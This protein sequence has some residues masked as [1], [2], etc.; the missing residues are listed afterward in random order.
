MV[1]TSAEEARQ[2]IRA[3]LHRGVTSGLAA[4]FVQANLVI[5]PREY[6]DDVRLLCRRN[7]VPC[8]LVDETEPGNPVPSS[9]PAADLRTDLSGYRLWR[10]GRLVERLPEIRRVWRSDLVAFLIGC[11]FTFE[12]ALLAAGFRLRHLAL[13]RNV[14]MYR[15][16]VPLMPAGRLRGHMV[17]SMRPFPSAQVERVRAITRPFVESHGEPVHWGDP[18]AIGIADVD[19]PDEGDHAPMR[20]GEVPVFWGC[21][22]TP[23]AVAIESRLPFVIT[24]E[25]GHMFITDLRHDAMRRRISPVTRGAPP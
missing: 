25:P 22:V 24:H 5:V 4:E 15:T 1:T 8:P 17:V 20:D 11:S 13:G 16:N 2:R 14:A 12:H 9:A 19:R 21:G 23:Q 7:P 18:A 3:G 6:A 10:D